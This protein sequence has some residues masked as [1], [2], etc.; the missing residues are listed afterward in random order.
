[1]HFSNKWVLHLP[2]IVVAFTVII[3]LSTFPR[4]RFLEFR[5]SRTEGST[6]QPTAVLFPGSQL[7]GRAFEDSPTADV[8]PPSKPFH[9]IAVYFIPNVW[10][11]MPTDEEWPLIKTAYENVL[12]SKGSSVFPMCPSDV[13]KFSGLES[14]HKEIGDEKS[15]AVDERSSNPQKFLI[16]DNASENST[17]Y[18]LDDSF[19]SISPTLSDD[20]LA[21]RPL[22]DPDQ[23][24]KVASI[25]EAEDGSES[26]DLKS[27]TTQ[28]NQFQEGSEK[29]HMKLH[30]EFN[31]ANMKVSELRE[32]LKARDLPTEGVKAQL[33]ARLKLAIHEEQESAKKAE[34]EKEERAKVSQEA[35]P[36]KSL[37]V[38]DKQTKPASEIESGSKLKTDLLKPALRD[39]PSLIILRRRNVDFSIQSVGLDVV[40]DSKSNFM[41]SRS[42]ELMFCVHT[43]FDMLRRDSVFTLFRAL[44]TAADRGICA[45][46]RKRSEPDYAAKRARLERGERTSVTMDDDCKE[47]PLYTTDLPL[48]FACTVLDTSYKSYFLSSEVEDFIL[49]LGLPMSRYQLRSLIFKVLDH[50]RFHYRSLT[51]SEEPLSLTNKSSLIF[52]DIDDD[53][54]LLELVRG[55][56]AILDEQTDAIPSGSIIVL[57]KSDKADC[58]KIS[59]PDELFQHIRTS[60]QEQHKL[61]TKIR[62]QEQEI[63]RLRASVADFTNLKEKLS[64]TVS[65]LEESRRRYR[66]ERDRVDSMARVLDQQASVLDAC[67]SA[68]RQA[69]SRAHSRHSTSE[70]CKQSSKRSLSPCSTTSNKD[71]VKSPKKTRTSESSIP[72]RD[73]T[74]SCRDSDTAN[75]GEVE[76][77][78]GAAMSE[79]STN[80]DSHVKEDLVNGVKN[81]LE[82]ITDG[83]DRKAAE[84]LDSQLVSEIK[85]T[86]PS[87]TV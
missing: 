48:L 22:A 18:K 46:P 45:K 38:G 3:I 84:I 79:L 65:I 19:K 9:Q 74:L 73:V 53:E 15:K 33:L 17:I 34:K 31:L 87:I 24:S 29:S 52:S 57:Q 43:I 14:T 11:L 60:E 10:S 62:L 58:S 44:V 25:C 30:N 82:T 4:H 81:E 13:K 49:S 1:M 67:R 54:Y 21:A 23:I 39:I 69:S 12:S 51:D 6:A 35:A 61:M 78:N 26:L 32:Q 40:M 64:K 5:Y 50:G 7:W 41:D 83:D 55:G 70:S 16:D 8:I 68:L 56:D 66:D 76:S 27:P 72:E 28:G 80:L 37:Q 71:S 20:I 47:V 36:E 86:E 77:G 2:S 75:Y 85:Q 42:Y 63:S 59:N